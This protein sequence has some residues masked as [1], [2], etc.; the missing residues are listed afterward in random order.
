MFTLRGIAFQEDLNKHKR[1]ELEVYCVSERLPPSDFF[2]RYIE[3]HVANCLKYC[4]LLVIVP[5][6]ECK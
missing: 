2:P 6:F 1:E 3:S 5:S 4:V